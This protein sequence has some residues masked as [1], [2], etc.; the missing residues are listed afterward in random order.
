MC[1]EQAIAVRRL[2]S[3]RVAAAN[4]FSHDWYAIDVPPS[5]SH[6]H[7]GSRPCSVWVNR[8][9]RSRGPIARL[10]PRRA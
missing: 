1:G 7:S 6:S 10:A 4:T 8:R 9:I 2:P 5:V 3:C